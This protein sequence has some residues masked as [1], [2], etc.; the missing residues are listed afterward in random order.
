MKRSEINKVMR[1]AVAFLK[2]QNFF[3]PQFAYW[4]VED[5]KTKHSEINEIIDNQL[6]WDITDFG[7]G[8]FYN[9]GLI[10][11]TIRNGKFKD[12]SQNA[13]PYCEK[14]MIVEE[15][16]YTPMHRHYNKKE[17]IINRGGGILQVETYKSSENDGLAKA[18][19]TVSIDGVKKTI[20]PG[21]LIELEPG[22]SIY[23]P[24]DMEHKFWG[25][26]G[27][28]KVLIGEVST[29]N[30]D[31]SDNKYYEE[32]KRFSDIEEDEKPLYLLYDD[33]DKY[34]KKIR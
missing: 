22:D 21:E 33:Y 28:G 25:K 13:K 1:D 2:E 24:T 12:T 15:E 34:L 17:D 16:Q 18:P 9:Y 26:K 32:V 11:F 10:L 30:D 7:R 3:L 29:V 14:V 5:W 4:T 31:Y 8:D 23:L 19:L 27:H 20:Q 6:G